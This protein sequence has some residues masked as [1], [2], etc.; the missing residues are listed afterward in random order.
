MI[1][2]QKNTLKKIKQ[3]KKHTLKKSN[4]EKILTKVECEIE[5]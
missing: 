3:P 2:I 5:A 1:N 4:I